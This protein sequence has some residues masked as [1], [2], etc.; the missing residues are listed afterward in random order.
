MTN[1]TIH[2]S[3]LLEVLG[4]PTVQLPKCMPF[5]YQPALHL[6]CCLGISSDTLLAFQLLNRAE[7]K[8]DVKE[9]TCGN[10]AM[11]DTRSK[12]SI[13]SVPM[14]KMQALFRNCWNCWL[15]FGVQLH[16][17]REGTKSGVK[18]SRS[19]VGSRCPTTNSRRWSTRPHRRWVATCSNPCQYLR[20]QSHH[21]TVGEIFDI[22]VPS[23]ASF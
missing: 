16:A 19:V 6:F 2:C 4:L 7:R 8:S 9:K 22:S 1:A 12:C 13:H 10:S 11:S 23:Y 21:S 3:S 5:Q 20:C 18:Q 14:L 15:R 17:T